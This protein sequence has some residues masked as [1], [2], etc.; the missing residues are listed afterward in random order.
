V[1]LVHF[2]SK[3]LAERRPFGRFWHTL[4]ADGGF[5][6]D[7]DE[8][9]TFTSH[10]VI[11]DLHADVTNIDPTGAVYQTLGGTMGPHRFK[12]DEILV[13]SAWRPNLCIAENYIS[14]GGKVRLVGDSCERFLPSGFVLYSNRLIGHRALP[15]GYGTNFGVEE[16]MDLGFELLATIKGY[17]G[18]FLLQCYPIERRP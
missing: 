8:L 11:R 10:M 18:P 7:Q 9:D 13:D 4:F 5:M 3:E 15:R 1:Y 2:R 14:D 16:A 17:A 12:I 6:I